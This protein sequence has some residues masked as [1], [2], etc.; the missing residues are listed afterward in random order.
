MSLV[1]I[2]M[3]CRN[4]AEFL[5]EALDSVFQQT[6]KDYEIIFW[7]NMSTD[8]S[9]EIA[10]NYGEPLRYFCGEEPL[11]LGAARNEAIKKATGKYIA[12]LDC[13][14]IW[15]PDNL[16]KQVELLESNPE[17][18]LTYS[19]CYLIDGEG[20]LKE[21]KR[22][23][24]SSHKGKAFLNLLE[25]NFIPMPTAM[26][27]RAILD[28]VGMFNPKYEVIEEYDLWLR[29][30]EHYSIGFTN[31]PLAKRRIHGANVSRNKEQSIG[32]QVQLL[33]YWIN[34]K[35]ELRK[36]HG[37]MIN[38]KKTTFHIYLMRYYLS[39]HNKKRFA[40]EAINLMRLF[41]YSLMI[42]PKIIAELRHTISYKYWNISRKL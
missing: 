1:S 36:K 38:Q 24:I 14:D 41:P 4:C 34:K 31:K 37:A 29:I 19:D 8:R 17:L 15:L 9:T 22:Y 39:S 30:A 42:L 20:K 27:R 13:D 35:P 5:Q 28:E 18:G 16:E 33:E 12:F 23:H 2:I 6:F 11:L 10:L 21:D 25:S 32:E 40:G 26:V 3:N 7:D